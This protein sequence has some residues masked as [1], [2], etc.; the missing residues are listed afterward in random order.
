LIETHQQADG[1]VLVPEPLRHHLRA[2]RIPA[3]AS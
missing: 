2:D 3:S 1:S